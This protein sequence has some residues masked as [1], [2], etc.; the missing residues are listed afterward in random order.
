[1]CPLC[2]YVRAVTT[3]EGENFYQVGLSAFALG[4]H[5]PSEKGV[6]LSAKMTA[7]YLSET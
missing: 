5:L 4:I 7:M 3:E 1:M 2:S 6:A